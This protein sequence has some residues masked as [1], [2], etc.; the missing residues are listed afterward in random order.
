MTLGGAGKK[1][2]H[3]KN[4]RLWVTAHSPRSKTRFLIGGRKWWNRWMA[5]FLGFVLFSILPTQT[6]HP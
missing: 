3:D 6:F 1:L 4:T 5:R 2:R